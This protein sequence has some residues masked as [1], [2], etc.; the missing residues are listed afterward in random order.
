VCGNG[1]DESLDIQ[2][3]CILNLHNRHPPPNTIFLGG[4]I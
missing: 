3:E 2:D 4:P 1:I